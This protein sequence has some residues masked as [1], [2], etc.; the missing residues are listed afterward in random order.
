MDFEE[1]LWAR[2]DDATV[3]LLRRAFASRRPLGER[4]SRKLMRDF[5]L[6]M[7]VGGM[8][9]TVDALLRT[10]D[11][12]A[13][14]DVKRVIVDLYEEDMHKISLSGVLS[15]LFDAVPAQLAGKSSRYHVS[16]VLAGRRSEDIL[17]QIVQLEDSRTVLIARHTDDPNAGLSSSVDLG[18]F[19]LYLADTGLF[20]ALAFKDADFTDNIVYGKLLSDKLPVNLGMVYENVVAQELTAHGR[21]LFYHTWPKPGDDPQ[22]RDRLHRPRRQEGQSRRGQVVELQDTRLVGRILRKVLLTRRQAAPRLAPRTWTGTAPS[23]ASRPTCPCSCR[24]RHGDGGPD[25]RDD[26]RGTVHHLPMSKRGFN[27]D[28]LNHF[29]AE[30]SLDKQFM[31]EILAMV[32]VIQSGTIG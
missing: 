28:G 32:L 5:R 7:L 26:A 13:V 6:Y 2:G 19:K 9:Q 30:S 3:P 29:D 23:T 15:M 17:E 10:N 24:E 8:P 31:H 22:L 20:V 16:S 14:D 1:F 27:E 12:L 25:R 11:L 4:L 21:R 18:K